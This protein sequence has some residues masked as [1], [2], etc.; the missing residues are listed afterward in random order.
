MLG[1]A[2]YLAPEQA[3]GE[4]ATPAS[5][6]YALAVVAFELLTG[7]APFARE[8]PTAEATAHVRE[9]IPPA[10][11]SNPDLPAEVDDV[12]E[13][14]A[15]EGSRRGASRRAAE[16]VA[17]LREALDAG[18]RDDARS[19]RR[20]AASAARRASAGAPRRRAAGWL[21]RRSRRCSLAGVLAAV[22]LAGG[23]DDDP[24]R[25]PR[26][27]RRRRQCSETITLPGTTVARP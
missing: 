22:L 10:S 3:R 12:L 8:S 18:G 13:R 21:A 14:G 23:D 25:R 11:S 24:A 17:A 9:P 20:R 2:G 4:P 5:D 6:R 26:R 27:P 15:R 1:T 19:R 7:S 16:L